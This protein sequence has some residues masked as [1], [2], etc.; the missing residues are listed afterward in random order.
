MNQNINKGFN[1]ASNDKKWKLIGII[2]LI[3]AIGG[4]VVIYTQIST[5]NV[6]YICTYIVEENDPCGN[7]NWGT[8]STISTTGDSGQCTQ[9]KTEKR[10]YTGTRE[11]RHIL[12]YL[13][14][15]T[16]CQSGYSQAQHGDSGGSSGFHG[17]SIVSETA[18]CQIE[19]TRTTADIAG[20]CSG[21]GGGGGQTDVTTSSVQTDTGTSDSQTTNISALEQ[22]TQFR[23]E[24]ID[25]QITADP[26]LLR[27][28]NTTEV[29]WQGVEVTA[30]TVTGSNGDSW[31]GTSGEEITSPIESVTTFTLNCT[32]FNDTQVQDS[33]E[34]EVLPEFQEM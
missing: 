4:F 2:A 7:G 24:K 17:G 6:D 5:A 30:C 3:I 22:L 21:G 33:V 31:S 18:A 10:I 29:R 15:R 19:E 34:V 20:T 8:W 11:T 27:R 1:S 23:E 13:S 12:Q 16:S 28:G 32:A 9:V 26:D 25:G 14:L